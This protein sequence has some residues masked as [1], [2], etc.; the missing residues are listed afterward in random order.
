M[1]DI[2]QEVLFSMAYMDEA[3]TRFED[4]EQRGRPEIK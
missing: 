4:W 2:P 3:I 1:S